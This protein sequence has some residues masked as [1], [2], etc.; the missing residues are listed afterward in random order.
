MNCGDEEWQLFQTLK[1]IIFYQ[2][3]KNSLV[4]YAD[5][6]NALKATISAR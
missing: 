4:T 3:I 5:D 1:T 2:E 6:Q